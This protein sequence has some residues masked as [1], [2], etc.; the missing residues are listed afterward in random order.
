[1]II[2]PLTNEAVLKKVQE[3]DGASVLHRLIHTGYLSSG[4]AL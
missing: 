4:I 3:F 1:M 2:E